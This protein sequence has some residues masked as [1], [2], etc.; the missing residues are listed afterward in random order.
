MR[1]C[2][3]AVLP[4]EIAS[5][6]RRWSVR[7]SDLRLRGRDVRALD[8]RQDFGLADQHRIEA[9]AHAEEMLYGLSPEP[10]VE[11]RFDIVAGRAVPEVREE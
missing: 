5:W 1:V 4:A 3:R 6:N 10:G 9:C 7:P 2:A 11:V 8:L